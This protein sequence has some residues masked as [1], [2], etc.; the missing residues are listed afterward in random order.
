MSARRKKFSIGG[1]DDTFV[2]DVFSDPVA[3]A[4]ALRTAVSRAN[5]AGTGKNDRL[6]GTNGSDTLD[7]K[8][9]NDTLDGRNGNDTLIGGTGRN[10]I[11]GGNGFDT[12]VLE[13]KAKS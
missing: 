7:G 2:P 6:T 4:P 8:A 11:V 12:A 1:N 10:I 9:G 5:V 13:G 3:H